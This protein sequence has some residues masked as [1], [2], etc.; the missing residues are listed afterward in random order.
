MYWLSFVTVVTGLKIVDESMF[1]CLMITKIGAL[2]MKESASSAMRLVASCLAGLKVLVCTFGVLLTTVTRLGS[3][4][5]Y[6]ASTKKFFF[7]AIGGFFGAGAAVF[8]F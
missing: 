2:C 6:V 8:W 5:A 3:S 4:P 7:I 1:P